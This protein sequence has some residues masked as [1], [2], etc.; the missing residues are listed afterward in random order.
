MEET[1]H[2]LIGLLTG[3]AAGGIVGYLSGYD[4]GRL[5][6]AVKRI[7]IRT[8]E[9]GGELVRRLYLKG[10]GFDQVYVDSDPVVFA[11]TKKVEE[12]GA[13]LDGVISV[14]V[15]EPVHRNGNELNGNE[16]ELSR[17]L[18]N[19]LVRAGANYV[20]SLSRRR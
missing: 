2:F 12:Q 20:I 11:S 14:E 1:G 17:K 16:F 8:A 10:Q 15:Y 9:I 4:K 6:R 3:G 13:S 18:G 7:E 5:M 19:P